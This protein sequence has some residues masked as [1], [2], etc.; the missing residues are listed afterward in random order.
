MARSPYALRTRKR[1][2]LPVKDSSS[3]TSP[4]SSSVDGGLDVSEEEQLQAALA[5]SSQTAAEVDGVSDHDLQR[6]LALSLEDTGTSNVEQDSIVEAREIRALQAQ[7]YAEA[8]EADRRKERAQQEQARLL[9]G[10]EHQQALALESARDLY[11]NYRASPS[12][13]GAHRIRLYDK[14][15]LSTDV[16]LHEDA[17]LEALRAAS[18]VECNAS[19]PWRDE[20][21]TTFPRKVLDAWSE[22]LREHVARDSVV[23]L[24]ER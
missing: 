16:W 3:P 14:L 6:A 7:E 11:T 2:T 17:P 24:S 21:S 19:T 1:P 10:A 15:G 13:K 20:L 22:P 23:R 4:S 12:A 9:E 18:I 5:I 8:L